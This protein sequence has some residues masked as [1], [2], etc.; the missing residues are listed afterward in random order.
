[1]VLAYI[2][3][4][5]PVQCEESGDFTFLQAYWGT[6]QAVEVSPGDVATLTVVLKQEKIFELKGLEATLTLPPGFEALGGTDNASIIYT[7]T[8]PMGSLVK[9]E[10]PLFITVDVQR[11]SY[12]ASLTLK[13]Y[14]M[15]FEYEDEL[16]ITFKV[17]GKPIVA[18]KV[19][20]ASLYEGEQRVLVEFSNSGDAIAKS[21]RIL[22]V[23]STS[24]S[25]ELDSAG[26][27]G[28]LEPED[29]VDV[30]LSLLVPEGLEGK[31]VLLTVEGSCLGPTNVVYSFT[32]TL[33]LQ[34]A[35]VEEVEE[36][37]ITTQFPAKAA[38]PGDTVRFTVRLESSFEAETLF[39]LSVD[40]VPQNW[41][42]SIRSASGDLVSKVILDGN[43]FVDLVVEVT[44]PDSARVGEE[45]MLI[46]RA[47]SH[48]QNITCS[49]PISVTLTEAEKVEEV[50]ITAK[51][52]DV[53]VE[54]AKVVQYP[55]TL[56]N[57]GDADKLLFLSIEP[58]ADWKAVFKSGVLEV[59]RLYMEAGKS[60]SLVIEVTPPST[61]GI[62]A[63]T[64]PVQVKS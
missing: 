53:T 34:V 45:H 61:V 23:S 29:N 30:M 52:P 32:E 55:I 60:E 31:T 27:L 35:E 56:A 33:Q 54:A 22:K 24:A 21:L 13:Y 51:F 19:L 18:A 1:M 42:V 14:A 47:E 8:V 50:K 46:V 11:G 7:G 64:I 49:L 62:G 4:A 28:N 40:S 58:P 15:G 25:V 41:T 39:K 6:A 59:S 20:N 43:A 12:T 36:A 63:Y 5:R 44:S 37:K 48:D 10:F 26:F 9:L 16:E 57:L 2:L 3:M 17:T 38:A